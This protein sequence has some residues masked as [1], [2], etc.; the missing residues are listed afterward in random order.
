MSWAAWPSAHARKASGLRTARAFTR[1]AAWRRLSGASPRHTVS[2]S[3]LSHKLII[4]IAARPRL[5]LYWR[6]FHVHQTSRFLDSINACPYVYFHMRRVCTTLCLNV[7]ETFCPSTLDVENG[8]CDVT[9]WRRAVNDVMTCR[10]AD[11]FRFSHGLQE[12]ELVCL[13]TGAWNL[14]QQTCTGENR[15]L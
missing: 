2:V 10:C 4:A 1:L 5:A 3:V 14:G 15:H 9:L 11:G 12:W 13:S 8:E 6:D 7:S